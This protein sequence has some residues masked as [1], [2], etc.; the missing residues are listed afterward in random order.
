MKTG[1]VAAALFSGNTSLQLKKVAK[2]RRVVLLSLSLCPF[3][4]PF[5]PLKGGEH[6]LAIIN[7]SPRVLLNHFHSFFV[8]AKIVA[9]I[10]QLSLPSDKR[11]KILFILGYFNRRKKAIFERIISNLESV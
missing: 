9:G 6:P 2:R 1:T 11:E 4:P 10:E 5:V 3:Q 7:R 8:V